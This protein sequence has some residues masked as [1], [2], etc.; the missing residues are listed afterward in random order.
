MP[1]LIPEEPDDEDRR[2]LDKVELSRTK[3]SVTFLDGCR[4]LF[5]YVK[6]ARDKQESTTQH[7]LVLNAFAREPSKLTL[8]LNTITKGLTKT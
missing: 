7:V 8:Q 6:E 4:T 1:C 3:P 2:G 5:A